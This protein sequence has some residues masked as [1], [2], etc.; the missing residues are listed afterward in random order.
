MTGQE[1]YNFFMAIHFPAD[2]LKIMDYNRCLKSL[3]GLTNEEF[4]EKVA[5]SYEIKE[6]AEGSDPK[7]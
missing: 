6:Q 2:H 1:P 5:D 3:N 7:P 4:L